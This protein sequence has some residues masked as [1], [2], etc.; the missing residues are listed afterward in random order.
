MRDHYLCIC[1]L[2]TIG[3]I[4][5]P[6]YSLHCRFIWNVFEFALVTCLSSDSVTDL[7]CVDSDFQ[8]FIINPQLYCKSLDFLSIFLR[9]SS[10][11][12]V[13]SSDLVWFL[14]YQGNFWFC[15]SQI[16]LKW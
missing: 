14:Q 2:E 11:N 4:C 10:L 16:V 12:I 6:I 3:I 7:L 9:I 8:Y 1:F 15:N 5:L 13:K